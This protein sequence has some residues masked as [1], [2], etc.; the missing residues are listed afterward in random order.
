MHK[1]LLLFA[2]MFVSSSLFATQPENT[3][4]GNSKAKNSNTQ[5]KK[6]KN[7]S[8]T[9]SVDI[10]FNDNHRR[11]ISKYYSG[12]FDSGFCPPGLAKKNNGCLPPGQV[13][14]WRRGLPLPSDVIYYDLPINI[15]KELGRPPEGHKFVRVAADILLIAIGTGI[16][17][18]AIE[19]LAD[20]L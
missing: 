4:Q 7:K 9:L 16:V 12:A 5:S 17:V 14:K 2:M 1:G 13:K 15:L 18:D 19:D 6:Y 11:V 3:G 20:L 8:S 10:Y